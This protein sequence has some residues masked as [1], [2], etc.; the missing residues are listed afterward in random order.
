[1]VTILFRGQKVDTKECVYGT[2]HYSND[3]KNHYILNREKMLLRTYHDNSEMALHEKEVHLVIPE[4][5]GQFTGLTDKN[6]VE[7]YEGDK[8]NIGLI[9]SKQN[10]IVNDIRYMD[11]IIYDLNRRVWIEVIGNIHEQ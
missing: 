1:M 2:Y 9:P 6:G 11:D 5:V 7:V 10:I 8:I 3:N 4:T